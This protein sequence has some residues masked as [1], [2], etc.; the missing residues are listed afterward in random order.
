M[1]GLAQSCYCRQFCVSPIGFSQERWDAAVRNLGVFGK[2]SGFGGSGIG[3]TSYRKQSATLSQG[4]DEGSRLE[5]T[6]YLFTGG[7]L[8][9]RRW[10]FYSFRSI[11]IFYDYSVNFTMIYIVIES[12]TIARLGEEIEETPYQKPPAKTPRQR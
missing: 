1:I 12:F 11:V 5:G 4:E 2:A 3:G 7:P 8:S 10:D 6:P 9:Y